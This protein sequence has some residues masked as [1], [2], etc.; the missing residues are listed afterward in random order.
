MV[1]MSADPQKTYALVVGVEKYAAGSNWN[2]DGPAS[3]ASKFAEWLRSQ[4]VPAENIFMYLSPLNENAGIAGSGAQAATRENVYQALTTI[5]PSKKEGTL[6]YL[7]WGGHGMLTPDNKRLLFYT[8]ATQQNILNLDLNSLLTSLRSN[9][10]PGFEQ[11]IFFIDACA[12]Y[13]VDWR[14]YGTL[15]RETFSGGD[16]LATREQFVC[17]AAKPGEYAKNVTKQQTGLF[18]QVVREELAKQGSDRWPPDMELLTSSLTERFNKLRAGG[19]AKQTPTHFWYKNWDG[20]ERLLGD[21]KVPAFPRIWNVP[22]LHNPFFTGRKEILETIHHG[23]TSP[24]MAPLEPQALCGMA[25]IGK[26]QIAL[27]YAH[28]YRN[29]Y[30]TIL[31]VKADSLSVLTSDFVGLAYL[32]NLPEKDEQDERPVIQAV[33][34]WFDI[35]SKWLLIFD[36][37]D[38]LQLVWEFLPTAGIG[39]I[40][41]TTQTQSARRLTRQIMIEQMNAEE[42]I[43]F[44]LRRANPLLSENA[45]EHVA[46]EEAALAKKIV[47]LM[48]GYPLALDQAGAYIEETHCSLSDYLQLYRTHQIELLKRRGN[49]TFEHPEFVATTISLSMRKVAHANFAATELLNFLAFLH[50]DAI[51]EEIITERFAI[52]WFASVCCI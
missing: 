27:E 30:D 45:L 35:H 22:F 42:G 14:L 23:F 28:H 19:E 15:P 37:A 46:V 24:K 36:S 47:K 16:P 38:D 4:Q 21:I 34:L 44:L 51:P 50:P 9:Y 40:L 49:S 48:E 52:S 10:F 20:T 29:E 7:F 13:V 43:R 2:L 26:T 32:L 1:V 12:N 41:L 8:D 6:F 3:D 39:H 5:L 33:K 18:S 25:G 31:W 11:Q 17:L